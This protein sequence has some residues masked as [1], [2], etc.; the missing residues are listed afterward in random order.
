M[1]VMKEAG[2]RPLALCIKL[3]LCS[4]DVLWPRSFGP[5]GSWP[6]PWALLTII[7]FYIIVSRAQGQGQV[8]ATI[9]YRPTY[10]S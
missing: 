3:V 9:A 8:T 2:H 1:E 5:L 6:W 7:T 4:V 10:A